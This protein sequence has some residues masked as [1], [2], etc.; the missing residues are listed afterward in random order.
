MVRSQCRVIASYGGGIAGVATLRVSP[1]PGRE[2]ALS[3]HV[4]DALAAL[5]RPGVTGG[6]LLQ[7]D[8]PK[9][10]VTTEQRIRG[11]LKQIA[12]LTIGE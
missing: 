5:P 8:T 1:Q 12:P 2:D 11:S 3:A 9:S 4:R 6:H 7:T 10:G